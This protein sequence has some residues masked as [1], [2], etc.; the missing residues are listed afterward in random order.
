MVPGRVGKSKLLSTWGFG[1]K[2]R[3]KTEGG[4]EAWI[5]SVHRTNVDAT[6]AEQRLLPVLTIIETIKAQQGNAQSIAEPL[7]AVLTAADIRA[8]KSI[9]KVSDDIW[10][11]VG[12][13]SVGFCLPPDNTRTRSR[14]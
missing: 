2:H 12:R 13:P 7:L 8:D 4:D 9:G 3:L 6:L 1:V 11:D 10:N 14:A 5:L